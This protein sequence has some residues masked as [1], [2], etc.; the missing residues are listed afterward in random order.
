M[1]SEVDILLRTFFVRVFLPKGGTRLLI[2][3]SCVLLVH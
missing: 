3:K 2:L 1:E